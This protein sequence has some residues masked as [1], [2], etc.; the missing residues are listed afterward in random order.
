MGDTRSALVLRERVV[1]LR[2]AVAAADPADRWANVRLADAL[3][4]L[5]ELRYRS[6][7][8]DGARAAL[9]RGA[10]IL[11]TWIQREP[12]NVNLRASLAET[13]GWQ[14]IAE[15]ALARRG[16]RSDCAKQLAAA[17]KRLLESQA[18]FDALKREAPIPAENASMPARVSAE[19]ARIDDE[20]RGKQPHPPGSPR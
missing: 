12:K 19:L 14:G 15:A 17:R 1:V 11:E 6:G 7:D 9:S 8:F 5:G 4:R 20:L 2:E 16:P 13:K 3:E 18:E 10:S